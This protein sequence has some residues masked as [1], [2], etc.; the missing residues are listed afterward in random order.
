MPPNGSAPPSGIQR[1]KD[2][3]R[4]KIQCD[5][6]VV[7]AGDLLK[8]TRDASKAA[9]ETYNQAL[10]AKIQAD[11]ALDDEFRNFREGPDEP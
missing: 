9:E 7:A 2:A 11:Q 5:K 6:A 4:K 3:K 8:R 1:L 10:S